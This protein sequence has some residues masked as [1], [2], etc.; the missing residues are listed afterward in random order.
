MAPTDGLLGHLALALALV[1][2]VGLFARRAWRLIRLVRTGTPE[3]RLD[4]IPARIGDF[5]LYVLGQRKLIKSPNRFAGAIH[6]TIFWGFLIITLGTIQLL[7]SGLISGFLLPAVGNDPVYMALL[8][9]MIVAVLGAVALATYRR[10]VL[11]PYRLTTKRDAWIILGLITLLMLSLILA[12]AFGIVAHP[13]TLARWS[14]IGNALAG[15]FMGM[16]HSTANALF[17]VFW[18]IHIL[19]V[20]SFLVYLPSSKHLHILTA[21]FTVFFRPSTPKGALA[22]IRDIEE[23]EHFGVGKLEQFGWKHLLDSFACTECGRCDRGC[24]ALLSGKPLSPKEVVLNIK[25]GL[26]DEADSLLA[27]K[28]SNLD[29]NTPLIGGRIQD[30]TLWSCTTCRWCVEACPVFIEHVPKILD[31]RR[32]LVLEESRFPA[33]V[34]PVFANLEKNGNPWPYPKKQRGAWARDLDVPAMADIVA[35][36]EQ[37]EVLYFVGCMGSYDQRNKKVATAIV[38]LLKAAGVKFAILGKEEV[39]TG[40]PARRIGNEY[41]YQTLAEQNIATL[42]EYGVKKVLTACAHCFNTIKNE[43]PQF[44]GS[45]EVVHH[46]EFLAELVASGRLTLDRPVES[47][48]TFH[49]PCYLGRYNDVYEPQRNV[50]KSLPMASVVEMERS[51]RTSFCCGGGGGR[52]FMEERTGTRISH[53]RIEQAMAVNPDT[54]VA[55]CPFCTTMFEDGNKGK[56]LEGQIRVRDFAEV[57]ADALREPDASGDP[58][59]EPDQR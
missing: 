12:E 8:D 49:D 14:F 22:P 5:A 55:A 30:E 37:I 27:G 21:P 58:A 33:E 36:G 47:T 48:M 31:M 2:A 40:D 9:V 4:D 38:T 6:A 39:C 46:T 32:N 16:N 20:L 11:K 56:N 59:S 25:Y 45:Y 35:A 26:F 15:L 53:L 17:G 52:S 29:G 18:W 13:S 3:H 34:Q 54:I 42:N 50:L 7:G 1:L 57:I 24:P 44:G 43:Y 23:Q 19:T 28:G 51:R 41:L 10:L